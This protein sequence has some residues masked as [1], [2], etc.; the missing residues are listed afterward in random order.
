MQQQPLP[1]SIFL[2]QPETEEGGVSSSHEKNPHQPV[3]K[4]AERLLTA[5][6]FSILTQHLSIKLPPI[7][8]SQVTIRCM[9]ES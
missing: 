9:E 1:Y 6:V 2:H 8:L 4:W 3:P 5:A 7:H